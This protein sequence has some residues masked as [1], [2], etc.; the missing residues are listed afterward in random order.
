MTFFSGTSSLYQ[1]RAAAIAGR[2]PTRADM[3]GK[4]YQP[5]SNPFFDHANTYL[6]ADVKSLFRYCRYYYM[7]HGIVNA[8]C[9][10]ASE[11]SV[12]DIIVQHEAPGVQDRWEELLLGSMDYRTLQFE[13]NL[14]Y[15]TFGNAFVSVSFPFRKKIKCAYCNAEHDAISTRSSWRYTKNQFWLT[16]P[17]CDASGF[18]Q[19]RDVYLSNPA[20]ITLVR[21]SPEHVNIHYNEAT[22]RMDYT[23]Q[24]S[25]QITNQVHMGRK[26]IV[27][28][29]PEIF[30]QAVKE[31]AAVVFDPREVFHLR[32]PSLSYGNRGWGTPLILPVLKDAFYMQIMKKAQECVHPDTFIDTH[33]GLVAAKEVMEGTLV[34]THTGSYEPV[35]KRKV[36]P[37]VS[38]RGDHT[39]QI[40]IAGVYVSDVLVSNNHP[41]Y[42]LRHKG[43]GVLRA[44]G[45][46]GLTP[47]YLETCALT[48][49]D[50]ERV[51][52][53]DYIGF[54]YKRAVSDQALDLTD[55]WKHT[56]LTEKWA[57]LEGTKT[58][59]E[60]FETF[61]GYPPLKRRPRRVRLTEGAAYLAGRFLSDGAF[62][63]LDALKFASGGLEGGTELLSAVHPMFP[64]A[65]MAC[66]DED[67][68][69]FRIVDS[70]L[71]SFITRWLPTGRVPKEIQEAPDSIVLE[72]LRG[73][74]KGIGTV[75][76]DTLRAPSWNRDLAYTV[77]RLA[78]SL[79]CAGSI[80]G[81]NAS[82]EDPNYTVRW[83][84]AVKDRLLALIN[85]VRPC[86]APS[87]P[88]GVFFGDHYLSLVRHVEKGH[89]D[90]VISFE[91]ENEHT[92]CVPAMATHNSI[93]LE[94]I[95]PQNFIYPQPAAQ[96]VDPFTSVDLSQWRNKVRAELARQRMDPAYTAIVPFPIGHQSIG[97]QGRSL[98]LMPEIQQVAEHI[99]VGMG[100]PT[101]LVF[102]N[103][104][105]A[106]TSVSMR[107]LENF[108]LANV[109]SQHRLL[110]W[111]TN[112]ISA[113]LGWPVPDTKFKPF[114][115]ADDLQRQ[116]MNF[117]LN[118]A[119]KISDT[120][121]LASGDFNVE[122]ESKMMAKEVS[123]RADGVRKQQVLSAEISAETM[124][125][126]ARA[127]ARA[128]AALENA[129]RQEMEG[130]QQH[131][132]QPPQLQN[133]VGSNLLG[134]G[135]MSLDQA[136]MAEKYLSGGSPVDMRPQPEQLPPRRE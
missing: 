48:W 93:L 84:G 73:Y 39:V 4:R 38:E 122:T 105:Y 52:V 96:G 133:I 32:K 121:L 119:G 5:F 123:I 99:S 80:D 6:P 118:Q 97:G 94:H 19:S 135:G 13:V 100:F 56:A 129:R 61:R 113:F 23:L 89:C 70:A 71:R 74:L 25:P 44:S 68:E 15:Q 18:A 79:K 62:A 115:M 17:K 28:T 130:Q 46:D 77:W 24:I 92:F 3:L 26:D 132:A 136:A 43:G 86:D 55:S 126:Q 114:R 31:K 50:A 33:D 91:V 49:E 83:E 40:D 65:T 128:E 67:G 134:P 110:K 104:N 21:W 116:G 35:I 7:T 85:N 88:G 76:G 45:S 102:G 131:Q 112:R 103:G 11:Y 53:G 30:L 95:I 127:Q 69:G 101:D 54:P 27:A 22:G 106:G 51:S 66:S 120:S 37:M 87:G 10:R 124:V 36:R 1:A 8:I 108:F 34:R 82:P 29:L 41:M 64:D 60:K 98:L 107:M 12:T 109:Q 16:C 117:Q 9:T 63:D 57:Y 20:D 75:E 125:I 2:T 59:A 78:L 90:E 58:Q 47:E 42:V 81:E 72:F 14:D 111:V